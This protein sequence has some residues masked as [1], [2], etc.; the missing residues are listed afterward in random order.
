MRQ[1]LP[2]VL[3]K[4]PEQAK[5]LLH[6]VGQQARRWADQA[7]DKLGDLSNFDNTKKTTIQQGIAAH[8][9]HRSIQTIRQ[10]L[11]AMFGLG[12]LKGGKTL[13]RFGGSILPESVKDGVTEF[14]LDRL[15]QLAQYLSDSDMPLLH[16]DTATPRTLARADELAD[17]VAD[18]NRLLAAAE[19]G[20]TGLFSLAGML[21]DL[22][23][24]LVIALRTI[25]QTAE[26]YGQDLSG[27]DGLQQIYAILASID[28]ASVGQKQTVMAGVASLNAVAASQGGL[29]GVLP[30]LLKSL[31]DNPLTER[32]ARPLLTKLSTRVGFVTRFL[33]VLGAVTGATYNIQMIN[34]VAAVAQQVFRT[35]YE[36]QYGLDRAVDPDQSQPVPIS[37]ASLNT[38]VAALSADELVKG[39]FGTNAAEV[40]EAAQ[41]HTEKTKVIRVTKTADGEIVPSGRA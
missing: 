30:K 39:V 2:K 21:L 8:N 35:A 4:A 29:I 14:S 28:Y 23:L 7:G 37:S 6:R 32:V 25:Y 18:R 13:E 16:G 22:P 34:S 26:C 10:Q 19:G 9:A 24:S 15:A 27:E 20:A 33:P 36:Q 31:G 17:L 40:T 3:P 41:N 1:L 11:P 5:T 12:S 38:D